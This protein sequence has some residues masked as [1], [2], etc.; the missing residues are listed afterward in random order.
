[1][2]IYFKPKWKLHGQTSPSSHRVADGG[3]PA[4]LKW[5][6][7]AQ[8]SSMT[9][10]SHLTQPAD[11]RLQLCLKN[12]C[13]VGIF[14]RGHYALAPKLLYF[15]ALDSFDWML[16]LKVTAS[17]LVI[18]IFYK[19]PMRFAVN[20]KKCGLFE[21]SYNLWFIWQRPGGHI[22]HVKGRSVRLHQV[23]K[24]P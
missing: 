21:E 5:C 4:S 3:G 6:P 24:H 18:F 14:W 23:I 1:M 11:A 8:P 10:S 20:G 16:M 22:G 2:L 19:I 7:G 13:S 15:R 9:Q 17:E 12:T